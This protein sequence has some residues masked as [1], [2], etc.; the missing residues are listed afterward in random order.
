[1]SDAHPAD[2]RIADMT[3]AL[4]KSS[5]KSIV[6]SLEATHPGPLGL[7][8]VLVR[9]GMPGVED[10]F[11]HCPSM[12]VSEKE[13]LSTKDVAP[14]LK[15]LRDESPAWKLTDAEAN[16]LASDTCAPRAPGRLRLPECLSGPSFPPGCPDMCE[17]PHFSCPVTPGSSWDTCVGCLLDF[18]SECY[19]ARPLIGCHWRGLCPLPPSPE[20]APSSITAC[21]FSLWHF[22]HYRLPRP[23]SPPPSRAGTTL[24]RIVDG[25]RLGLPDLQQKKVA[26][27]QALMGVPDGLTTPTPAPRNHGAPG[28]PQKGWGDAD[29]LFSFCL[30]AYKLQSG[31]SAMAVHDRPSRDIFDTMVKSIQLEPP[32]FGGEPQNFDKGWVDSLPDYPARYLCCRKFEEYVHVISVVCCTVLAQ[33]HLA[34]LTETSPKDCISAVVDTGTKALSPVTGAE[35]VLARVGAKFLETQGFAKACVSF[36]EDNAASP[37]QAYVFLFKRVLPS[38]DKILGASRASITACCEGYLSRTMELP[39]KESCPAWDKGSKKYR[40]PK[41]KKLG[42]A[43]SSSRRSASESDSSSD[44]DL[45]PRRR[46][47]KPKGN[48]KDRVSFVKKEK[49]KKEK[50]KKEKKEKKVKRKRESSSED[51]SGDESDAD[52]K[53]YGGSKSSTMPCFA[54]AKERGSCKKGKSCDFSHK[55]S[56]IDPFV[57]KKGKSKSGKKKK[58]VET[59][60]SSSSDS[61]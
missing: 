15:T 60:S 32:S 29:G 2:T 16:V 17:C 22:S 11:N 59:S 56:V 47:F 53:K 44:S 38:L 42:G 43:A 31:G 27:A 25:Y 39:T 28:A 49:K 10:F 23:P 50:K 57:A 7:Y 51:S 3:R 48:G 1:M 5:A 9:G 6:D 35:P 34:L 52:V 18:C 33:G 46:S 12:S 26:A 36:V 20:L 61:D 40:I 13:K 45:P 41:K 30:D 4:D 14:V 54:E 37:A 24:K 21:G 8:G 55:P 58:K 19:M